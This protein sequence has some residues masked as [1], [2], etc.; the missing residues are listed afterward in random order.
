[1][2]T[3]KYIYWHRNNT[4]DGKTLASVHLLDHHGGGRLAACNKLT[5]ELRETFPDAEDENIKGARVRKSSFV[6]GFTIVAWTSYLD[7]GEYEGWRQ[8]DNKPEYLF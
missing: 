4:R 1:M 3:H 8:Y 5:A 7:Q 2:A 6:Y